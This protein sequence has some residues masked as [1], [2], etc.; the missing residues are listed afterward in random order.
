MANI[1]PTHLPNNYKSWANSAKAL[2]ENSFKKGKDYR[3]GI[4]YLDTTE[5][6]ED[7]IAEIEGIDDFSVWNDNETASN[8]EIKEGYTKTFTQV[9]YGKEIPIG[10]LAKKFQGKNVNLLKR[11]SIQLGKRAY[12]MQQKAPFSLLG[13]GF[14]DTNT[15]LTGINGATVSALGPDGK[16]LFSVLHPCG[17][18]NSSTWSNVLADGA[19]VSEDALKAMLE[20][21]DGQSDGT[22]DGQL[23]AKGE[24]KHYGE[25]GYIWMV[26][27]SYF[28]AAKRIIGSELRPETTENDINVYKDTFDGKTI[29]VRM[30]PWLSDFGSTTAHFLIAKEVVQEEMP[31]CVL[32]SENFYTDDYSDK[33][34]ETAYVR[35][36]LG[37]SVGFVSPRGIVGSKGDGVAYSS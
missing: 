18:N 7:R 25:E 1:G 24:K 35:G 19:E 2:I 22:Y 31:L 23:D 6:Y 30:V 4:F 12:R 33:R 9:N 27:M 26:P 32:T 20:N 17:P 14:S 28:P 11:A 37:F 21:L 16:R 29:E 5:N 36:R 8:T 13:Y 3:Q 15:Y 34:T 10:R